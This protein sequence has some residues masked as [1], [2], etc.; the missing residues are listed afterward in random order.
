[1]GL[2]KICGVRTEATARAA[3]DADLVGLNFVS[4]SRRC[5]STDQACALL[6]WIAE[7]QTVAVFADQPLDEMQ[8]ILRQVP[9]AWVQLHGQEPPAVADALRREHKLIR[10]IAWGAPPLPN[11]TSSADLFLLDHRAPGAGVPLPWNKLAA[12]AV[13]RPFLLAGGLNASNVAEAI[14]T[15]QPDGVD[16]ASG[17]EESGEPSAAAISS[18]IAAARSAWAATENTKRTKH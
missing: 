8:H 12:D 4:W 6:R 10:S 15:V 5:I 2:V 9:A 11:A 3:R 7:E 1:M 17:A 13:P 18:F 16:T 14:A